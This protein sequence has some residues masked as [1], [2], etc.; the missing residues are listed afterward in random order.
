MNS[1]I[2]AGR[3]T[4]SGQPIRITVE[5]GRIAAIEPGPADETAWLSHGFIDLQ[6]NGY[7]GCDFNG[8]LD[9]PDIVIS[10][11][12]K[13]IETGTTTFIPTVITASEEKIVRALRT[14]AEARRK[15]PLV[16]YTMPFVQLEGPFISPVDG[17]VGAHDR[18]Y[19]RPPS[20]DEFAR[21]QAASGDLVGRV[22]LSPHWGNALEF[23]RALAGKGIRI[24]IGHTHATP[25]Q[26][27]AAAQAGATL[28]THL[29]N[30]IAGMLPRHPNPIWTQLA[31]DRLTAT[32]IAD[33]HHLPADALKAMVRAKGI[34]RSILISDAVAVGGMEPGIYD[35]A[36]GGAVELSAEGRVGSVDSGYLAGAALPIKDGIAWV[37]ASGVCE[38]GDAVRMATENPGRIV[39]DRG[40]LRVGANA[41]LVRFTMNI[42]KKSMQ[43]ENVLVEGVEMT[44]Q[45][46]HA[47]I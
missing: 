46:Q 37:A 7:S 15:S 1:R 17:A 28:S 5:Q 25:E 2:I 32:F 22:T 3:N 10:L 41:D 21:W 16:A 29:G 31:D 24:S 19:V 26:I 47:T 39:G 23:I 38:L 11:A 40:V 43:I 27:H 8:E 6:I 42:E 36:V 9:D 35:T 14:I 12:H 44:D 20:M 18:E 33:G 45:H 30:G 13:V 34:E 4:S